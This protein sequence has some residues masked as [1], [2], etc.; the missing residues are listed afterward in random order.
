MGTK[1]KLTKPQ[2]GYRKATDPKV[3]CHTCV[4]LVLHGEQPATCTKVQ[5]EVDRQH[6]CNEWQGK[7][8]K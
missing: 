6:V 1:V 3:A 8:E 2:A 7:S 5:G 4:N